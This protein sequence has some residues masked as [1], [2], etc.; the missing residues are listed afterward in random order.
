MSGNHNKSVVMLASTASTDL[1]AGQETD[2]TLQVTVTPT[3]HAFISAYVGNEAGARL[4]VR[5]APDE[6][7]RIQHLT[8]IS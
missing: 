4:R 7:A 5:I 8:D 6:W 2:A 3:G 1:L